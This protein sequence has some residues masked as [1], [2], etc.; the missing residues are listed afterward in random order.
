MSKKPGKPE[1]SKNQPEGGFKSYMRS[2][3][4]ALLIALVIRAVVIYPFRIP[5]GSMEDTLL[6]GDFL[7]AN[8]FVYGLRSP[9]WIGIPYTKIGFKIPFFRTPGIRKPVKGDV[10]IFKYPRDITLNYIK[11]CVGVSGDTLVVRD[12]NLFVNGR[13]IPDAPKSK[14]IYDLLPAGYGD[15]DIF[16]LGAGN[17]DNYGPVRVPAPGDTFGFAESMKDKWF[18]RLQLMVYEGS[19]VEV[20]TGGESI[21]LTVDNRG[22]WPAAIYRL[23]ASHFFVDGKPLAGMTYTVKTPHYFMMGDNRDN[24]LDSRY[25]GFLP[26]RLVVGEA[27]IIYWSW[28]PDVPLYRLFHKLRWGRLLNLIR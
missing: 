18:E 9:D 10:V 17:R 4:V 13:R 26:E 19:R 24:S 15:A 7:L 6:V 14:Y 23:D 1:D 21:M 11:R 22:N 20:R 3:L 8:K 2:F 25:W 5:T 16:P 28:D 12:K 27:L